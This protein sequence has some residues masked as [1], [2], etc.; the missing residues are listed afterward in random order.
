MAKVSDKLEGI[1]DIL[2][3]TPKPKAVDFDLLEL[4]LPGYRSKDSK[5]FNPPTKAPIY[6]PLPGP[7]W[8]R[9]LI[10]EP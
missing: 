9:L 6:E 5:S 3:D 10:I 8:F 4:L 1:K 7:G 2:P